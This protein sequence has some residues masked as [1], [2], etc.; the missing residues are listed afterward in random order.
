MNITAT[1][2]HTQIKKNWETFSL[3]RSM[4]THSSIK[5][6][7]GGIIKNQSIELMVIPLLRMRNE[8]DQKEGEETGEQERKKRKK[9]AVCK[10]LLVP[11]LFG[12]SLVLFK[13]RGG[14]CCCSMHLLRSVIMNQGRLL[15]SPS[16]LLLVLLLNSGALASDEEKDEETRLDYSCVYLSIHP[17]MHTVTY[18]MP[19]APAAITRASMI[20]RERASLQGTYDDVYKRMREMRK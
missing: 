17:S 2:T 8:T 11:Y 18:R 15:P 4:N 16:S 5:K 7:G 13:M 9:V 6:K 3:S 12:L 10:S 19:R 1:T 14:V 20:R